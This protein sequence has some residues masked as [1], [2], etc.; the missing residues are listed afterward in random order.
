MLLFVAV[1]VAANAQE[2]V[3]QIDEVS[4]INYGDGRLLFRQIDESKTP[5]NGE[6]RIIDGYRSEFILA[7]FS[8]GMYNGK[9][10]Y[11]KN[12]KLKEEGT[13]KDGR[14]D[15]VYKE[16]Q[17]DGKTLKKET[18][19]A[20][21]KL[22]GVMR[23]F[24]TNGSIEKEKEYKMSEE[25]GFERTYDFE[26][27]KKK[28][29]RNYKAGKQHGVQLIYY[30]SNVGDFVESS[31]YDDGK[32]V[33]DYSEIFSDGTIKKLGQYNANGKKDGEWLIRD[34]FSKKDN[35]N[36]SGRRIIYNNGDVVEEEEIRDFV[37]FQR[38]MNK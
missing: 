5:L 2:K 36:F 37:K 1:T 11:F 6:H 31:T 33:G 24:F 12:N 30:S 9:F 32:C 14:K 23:S 34:S 20:N 29:E 22:N 17:Y 7:E 15:G 19:Y 13:Y 3:Y 27:G 26:T 35:D 10:Q 16:Y 38:K 4:V 8:N 25:D 21:G 18:A 28:T